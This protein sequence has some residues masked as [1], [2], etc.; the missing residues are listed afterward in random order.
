MVE[1]NLAK[2]G[3]AGPNPVFR[4][5]RITRFT[6]FSCGP[7]FVLLLCRLFV[8]RLVDAVENCGVKL[9]AENLSDRSPDG[10]FATITMSR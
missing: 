6:A 9:A 10:E 3:V 2:V 7:F 4:S 5:R 8:V 1:H